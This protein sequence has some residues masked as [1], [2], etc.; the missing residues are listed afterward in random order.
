MSTLKQPVSGP[1]DY[2]EAARLAARMGEKVTATWC[3]MCGPRGNCAVY[4]FSR[5]GV[6]TRVAGMKEAPHNKGG[7][8]CK[9]HAAP[10]WV[11]SGDRL[12]R[13]LLRTGR[14]GE[15]KFRPIGWEEALQRMADT[16]KEQKER[17]GAASLAILSPARRDYSE[18]LYRFLMAHGSPNYAHSGICAMQLFFGFCHTIGARPVPDYR[19]ADVILIWGRQPVY[20]GPPLGTAAALVEA[21][22]RGARIY[23]IKPSLEADGAFAT[24]WIAVRPGTDAALALAMLHVITGEGLID[25]EFVSRWCYGYEALAEHVKQYGPA[26]AEGICG[27]PAAQIEEMARTYATAKKAAID[28]G[29]GLEHAPSSSGAIRAIA[30]LMAVTGHLDRPGC[31]LFPAPASTMPA[32]RSVHMKDRYDETWVRNIVG[33]EFPR[34]FQPFREGTSAAYARV[35]EDVLKEPPSIHAIIAPGTQPTVSTRNPRGT[36][37]ALEKVDFYAVIDTHRT[38]DM[39]Y[40][41]IVL[42]ALTP[43]ETD[44][45]FEVRGPFIMARRRAADPVGEGRSMQQIMLDLGVAMGYGEEFW[46]GDMEACMN[47]QLEPLGLTMDELRAHPTGLI[48]PS[49][50]REFER[51][52]AVFHTRS[53]RLDKGPY[54][55]QGKVA[56]YSTLLEEA[57]FD[58]MPCWKEPAEGVTATPQLLKEY[59]FVLSD[60]HTSRSFSAGWQRNVPA[61]REVEKEPALHI[62]PESARALGI[63]DGDLV[64]VTSPH[65]SLKVRACFYHGIRKD[66]VMLLHGWWQGCPELGLPDMPLLDGGANVNLLYSPDLDRLSDP[67]VTAMGSQTL[68]NVRRA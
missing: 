53:S 27:V 47:W 14:R 6:L 39:A 44:H 33:P 56:L 16:L 67:L 4:A 30:A 50:P 51:Y 11:Y 34:R 12:T 8:C 38:A 28:A 10:Q 31:N 26:W 52:D 37:K 23:A 19:H 1:L 5:D 9:A 15:G 35:F 41:D 24:D 36:I 32:P 17:F 46:Q 57:G 60:Y 58:P 18:Y 48:Y 63:A 59:P 29:N 7:L 65:G 55:P 25:G 64:Q 43:Y 61:L 20:S 68:V 49:L 21:R 13:P 42:P 66:T 45:P 2:E 40:A 3:G 62:H 54:L 22:Q